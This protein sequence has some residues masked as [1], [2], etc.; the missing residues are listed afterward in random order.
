M[1]DRLELA[2]AYIDQHL[3][4]ELTLDAIAGVTAY[5]TFHFARA[6]KEAFGVSVMEYVRRERLN[7]AKLEIGSGAKVIEAALKYGFETHAGFTKAFVAAF[8]CAPSVFAANATKGRLKMEK[9]T[10]ILSGIP[11]MSDGNPSS[12]CF[13][14]TVMRLLDTLG[15]PIE[16]DELIALSGVGLCFPWK[17]NSDCDEVG[18][19]PEIPIGAFGAL[20]YESKY[21]TEDMRPDD[22]VPGAVAVGTWPLPA[23][24]YD[25]SLDSVGIR[26]GVKLYGM[27]DSRYHKRPVPASVE[28]F[29]PVPSMDDLILGTWCVLTAPSGYDYVLIATE[30]TAENGGRV[31]SKEFYIE[32]IRRSIDAGRPVIGFGLVTDVH[33]C[34]ITGYYDGGDG[35]FVSSYQKQGSYTTDWYDK[36]RGILV[37]GEKTGER[38]TGEAAYKQLVDWAGWFRTARSKPVT[39]NGVTYPLGEAA[40]AAMCRWLLDD[41]E[42]Q[43]LSTHESF[44]KQSG[45]LLAGYYRSNLFS[46]MK[47]LNA[48]YPGVV[49]PPALLELERMNKHFP[50]S[51]VGDLWLND[52]VDPAITDFSMLRDHAV[53]EKVERYVSQISE[54]DN[55]LQWT[56]FMP[57]FVRKQV[58]DTGITLEAF[59]YRTLPAM[60]FIGVEGAFD[61]RGEI[62]RVLDVMPQYA[63]GFDYDVILMHH[64]GHKVDEEKWHGFM[65]RFMSADTPVPDGFVS[66]DFVPDDQG[67]PYLTFKSQ[68][69]FALYAGSEEALHKR[70]GFD[71]DA[72]YD[73]TRNIILGEDVIIPYPETYWTAEVLFHRHDGSEYNPENLYQG[74]NNAGRVHGGYLFSVDLDVR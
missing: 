61:R 67:T 14:G 47:R 34:L 74:D 5:S 19:I 57:D 24:T 18:I 49:N 46:Y 70:A 29:D 8:G 32:K 28:G 13:I 52:C 54:I 53:R 44:L 17:F 43:E 15:D 10:K 40:Y 62:M 31:Y 73:I 64:Y 38:L 11:E 59:A 20:G 50:G 23:G 22:T 33:A 16:E 6:F 48:Q 69:A 35:L 12:I 21:Y 65:G 68:F 30:P 36:C 25:P 51:E 56:L 2:K 27:F 37:V 1:R 41:E 71:S 9:V 58:G 55:C 60:R 4:D 26:D 72:M 63:S 42:W 39:A 7:A 3:T 66:F 45:L